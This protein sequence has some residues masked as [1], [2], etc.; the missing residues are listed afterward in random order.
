MKKFKALAL[1]G[2]LVVGLSLLLIGAADAKNFMYILKFDKG[3]MF[4]DFDP[5]QVEATLSKEHVKESKVNIKLNFKTKAGIG[6]WKPTRAIWKDFS[7]VKFWAFNESNE[8]RQ[9]KFVVKGAKQPPNA[10]T[11]RMDHIC[12]LPP[13]ESEHIIDLKT[14]KC[15]DGVSYLD[16]SNIYLYAFSNPEEKP[17]TVYISDLQIIK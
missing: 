6:E 16:L 9:L 14:E 3:E 17:L 5:A 8:E 12:K 7:K 1:P 10:D 4:S 11:N 13:G 2:L 15:K